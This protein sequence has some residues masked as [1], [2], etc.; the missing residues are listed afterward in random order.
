MKPIV[1]L[2]GVL[3][4]LF[5]APVW[6]T[7]AVSVTL[8][9]DRDEATPADAVR[10][11]VGVS[12]TKSCDAPPQIK[13]LEPFTV[14]KGGTSSRVEIVNGQY[15][16]KRHYVYFIQPSKTGTFKIGPVQVKVDGKAYNSNTATLDVVAVSEPKPREADIFLTASLSAETAYVEE[17]VLYVLKLYLR[18]RVSDISLTLPETDHLGFKQ[19]EKPKEY[20]ATVQGHSYGVV[21]LRYS[22][23]PDQPGAYTIKPAKIDLTV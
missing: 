13:G 23:I 1:S 5:L 11:T 2:I 4:W 19:L 20:R 22:L 3:I 10:L 14:S 6:A 17:E 21:E 15:T 18:K 7:A 12:G 9:L 16:A 8:N